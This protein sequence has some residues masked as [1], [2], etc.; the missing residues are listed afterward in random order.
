MPQVPR[1]QGEALREVA[2]Q[3]RA[4]TQPATYDQ[5]MGILRELRLGTVPRNESPE[6]ARAS[7]AKLVDDLKDVPV[8]ILRT[9]CSAYTNEAGTRFFP[10]GAGELRT[11]TNPLMAQRAVRAYRLDEMARASD[12]AFD[13]TTRCTPEQAAAIKAEFKLDALGE[14]KRD[15][16][17]IHI[18]RSTVQPVELAAHEVPSISGMTTAEI[19]AQRDRIRAEKLGYATP[20]PV[21][22]EYERYFEAQ[23]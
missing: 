19:F 18:P 6:E 11:Y 12:E 14:E 17:P 13:E 1:G 5:R 4:A 9:A 23:G 21:P 16:P 22:E 3:Y 15:L 20:E 2:A 8:D 7:F 10:R